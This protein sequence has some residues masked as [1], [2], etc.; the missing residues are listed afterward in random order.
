[1]D[2]DVRFYF[3]M[4]FGLGLVGLGRKEFGK[5]VVGCLGFGV[6]SLESGVLS[7]ESGLICCLDIFGFEL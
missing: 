4:E 3:R 2:R 6:W 7:L 5:V 1:M